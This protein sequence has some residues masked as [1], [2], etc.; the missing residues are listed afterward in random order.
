MG[1]SWIIDMG[2]LLWELSMA[3]S[4]WECIM[5]KSIICQLVCFILFWCWPA[6]GW[7]AT[8]TVR[9]PITVDYP[10]IRS[11]LIYSLY[12]QPGGRAA[13][14]SECARMELWGPEVSSQ[15]TLVKTSSHL[16]V[17]AGLP[18]LG[19]CVG[20]VTWE[21]SIEML[22]QVSLDEKDWKLKFK[23]VDSRLYDKNHAPATIAQFIFD[24]IRT[25]LYPYFDRVSVDLGPLV[26]ELEGFLPLI[27]S[28]QKKE[29]VQKWLR[30]VRPSQPQIQP[31]G[32]KMNILMDVEALPGVQKPVEKAPPV[33]LEHLV[34]V[35]ENLDAYFVYQ[36]EILLG[37]PLTEKEK[38]LFI[39][40][41]LVGRYAFIQALTEKK[42]GQDLIRE[43]FVSAWQELAPVLRKYLLTEPSSSLITYLS[44][45][46]AADALTVLDRLGPYLGI[47]ITREGLLR[48]ASLL[49]GGKVQPTLSYSYDVDSGL[50][51]F[52]GLTPSLDLDFDEP[53][54]PVKPQKEDLSHHLSPLR[55]CLISQAE[56][57][58]LQELKKWVV[59]EK[60]VEPYV[61]RVKRV[62]EQAAVQSVA[63]RKYEK[64]HT[65]F[66]R[67][68]VLAT[69]WQE[70]CWRQ[71][72]VVQDK[73]TYL[74]SSNQSS[75]GLM[76]INER[77]WRGIY[78][79]QKL[80]WEIRYNA[81]A[82][83][84]I[85]DLYWRKFIHEREALQQH[86]D[87]D[88][89][90]QLSYAIY[91]GGPGDLKKFLK[92]KEKRALLKSD[93]L[94]WEKY[95]LAKDGRLE[96]VLDCFSQK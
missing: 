50:R 65:A 36:I 30:T 24:R 13:L 15:G 28:P 47:E 59:P 77:V 4:S 8:E 95:R 33:P 45:F 69:A 35:W 43:Q 93:R 62:L 5:V 31:E 44:F 91:N 78:D 79:L 25:E 96:K 64:K 6:G 46:T 23:T 58:D 88:T 74:L 61:D 76:Q 63:D 51:R 19:N 37:R 67:T 55:L 70:S 42:I 17:E 26:K 90:A 56:A 83:S 94:F 60:G 86:F 52:F 20:T 10:F 84:E 41:W 11:L 2:K 85:L 54:A 16:R 87:P 14:V 32:V 22:Q 9:L 75:I 29:Q 21:G 57:A 73:I 39:E 92:R 68:L 71:F 80:R 89:Q 49:G 7:S 81:R 66:H 48:L 72:V 3:T 1:H 27:F 53:D 40:S 12:T 38:N 18:I 82:G 34:N